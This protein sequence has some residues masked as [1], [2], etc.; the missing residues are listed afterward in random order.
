[1]G[2]DDL[3]LREVVHRDGE[4]LFMPGLKFHEVTSEEFVPTW[5]DVIQKSEDIYSENIAR[6]AVAFFADPYEMTPMTY[7]EAHTPIPLK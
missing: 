6:W 3:H 2:V 4:A 5:H 1:M 7:N